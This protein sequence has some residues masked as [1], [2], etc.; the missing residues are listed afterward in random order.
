M[1]K[2]KTANNSK[3]MIVSY[4]RGRIPFLFPEKPSDSMKKYENG[5]SANIDPLLEKYTQDHISKKKK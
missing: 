2:T 4:I 3:T 1:P 5:R